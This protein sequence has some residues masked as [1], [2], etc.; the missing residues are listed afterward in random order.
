MRFVKS[1]DL[2]I[3]SEGGFRSGKRHQHI[4]RTATELH[5]EYTNF[6]QMSRC[7][8]QSQNA[9]IRDTIRESGDFS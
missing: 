2:K 9:K 4:Y 1:S 8:M 6:K 3:V 5:M 7:A